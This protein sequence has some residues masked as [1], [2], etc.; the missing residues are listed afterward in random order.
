MTIYVLARLMLFNK[1]KRGSLGFKRV[2][3]GT[4]YPKRA[5][6]PYHVCE[7]YKIQKSLEPIVAR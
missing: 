2:T 5:Y 4:A 7:P 6:I 1:L 3:T